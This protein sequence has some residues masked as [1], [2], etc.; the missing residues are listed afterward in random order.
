MKVRAFAGLVLAVALGCGAN[1]RVLNVPEEYATI[2]AGIDAALDGDTVLVAPGVYQERIDFLGK[3][4]TVTSVDPNDAAIVGYTIIDAQKQGSAVTFSSYASPAAVL[5]GF[6]IKG[7]S[8]TADTYSFSG[9]GYVYN[10]TDYMGGGIYC[11]YGSPTITRNVIVSNA[12]PPSLYSYVTSGDITTYTDIS[13][14]GGGIYGSSATITHNV[15]CRNTAYYG[16]GIYG[17]GTVAD[18]VIY[19]NTASYGGGMYFSSYNGRVTNNTFVSNDCSML[20]EVEGYGG[21]LYLSFYDVGTGTV[22]NN[23]ICNADSGGG[24]FWYTYG[25]KLWDIIRY[26][27]VWGN[28][29]SNYVTED[30]S[31]YDLLTGD[32]ADLTGRYGNVSANPAFQTG[33]S[34]RYRLSVNSPCISAGD[35]AFTPLSDAETDIDGD[36]RVY[37]LRVDIGADEYVGYVKPQA[38][39]GRDQHV[40]SPGLV[41]LDGTNSYISD[42]GAGVWYQWTQVE[43]PAVTLDDPNAAR[44]TFTAPAEGTYVFALVVRD[45]QAV[46]NPDQVLILVG[47]KKPLADAGPDQL[48]E[49]P[50]YV[51]LDGLDSSDADGLD[52]LSYSWTQVEGP[53]VMMLDPNSAAPWFLCAAPGVYRFQLVVNDGFVDS[54]PD[55]VKI[56]AATFTAGAVESAVTVLNDSGSN[57]CYF[58]DVSGTAVVYAGSEDGSSPSTWVIYRTDT[59]SGEVV[60]YNGG[61]VD[62]HPRVDGDVTVWAGASSS[63]YYEPLCT[64]LYAASTAAGNTVVRLQNATSTTSYGW[65]AIAGTKIVYLRHTGVN[66]S[67]TTAYDNASFDVCGA[68][69]SDFAHPVYFTIAAQAGHGLPYDYSDYYY[70]AYGFVDISGNIVVW[71]R[72]GDIWG[73][74][75][76]DIKHI[77]TF[78]ICTAPERQSDPAISGHMVVWKDA[79]NDDGDIYGAD[80]SDPNQVREFEICVLR[81]EQ[82][83]PCVDGALA[84]WIE[85]DYYS[86]YVTICGLSREYGAIDLPFPNSMRYDWYGSAPKIHGSTLVWRS[87]GY[88]VSMLRLNIS[89]T[90]L[91]GTIENLTTGAKYGTIQHAISAAANGDV[92]QVPPGV[93]DERLEIG[94][95]SLTI[96]STN[97]SDPA[98]RAATVIKG[99]GQLVSFVDEE[100]SDCVFTGFTVT[101]GSI[102]LYLHRSNPTLSFCDITGNRDAGMKIWGISKPLVRLC[103][104]T[105]NGAGVEMVMEMSTRAST[106]AAPMFQNCLIAGNRTYGLYG[107]DPELVNCT[108]ADNG[109]LGVS[110]NKPK[111]GNSIV[112][113]NNGGST[114]VQGKKSLAVTYSDIQGGATGE[115]NINL[116]PCFVAAG[117]WVTQSGLAVTPAQADPNS[118]WT[119]GDYHLASQGWRWSSTQQTWV[120]DEKTSPCIDAG[121]PGIPIGDEKPCET[122]DPLSERA[123]PNTRIDMGV[124]GGTA[125]A[126]L[127]PKAGAGGA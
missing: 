81:G 113:F 118:T 124:C 39:A 78:P 98:V 16:G 103:D 2:Q 66:T 38:D 65:P 12:L 27:N 59:K 41:T 93:Y 11:A 84:A 49:A 115:G 107:G 73:A 83:Y 44:P 85:G 104:V 19:D 40:L 95:K 37:A 110:G 30:P 127:A 76:S 52:V 120:W 1:A 74:D 121:D 102:G 5:A 23:L 25:A 99:D 28:A 54:E 45:N 26:N 15:I 17:G 94:G 62:T 82:L 86:G 71:E 61:T 24:L 4:I 51:S 10:Q 8:G 75:I 67:D 48:C 106:Y 119:R 123:G 33:S 6:T 114:N 101:G 46:S 108:V 77:K 69:I 57:E 31:T 36:P 64:S 50:G 22:A 125:E 126:S 7:G 89:H 55:E 70:T 92:I 34:K 60:K 56:E 105:A 13:S 21:N 29:S 58:T 47:N 80:I 122:G 20:P 53:E 87:S 14:Y 18:N 42:P 112:Y 88:Q 43:G 116:D 9:S 90:M 97:P 109:S 111:I 3:D 68:D 117:T 100:T 32:E 63:Y 91:S 96:T 79:R 35:P 72:D